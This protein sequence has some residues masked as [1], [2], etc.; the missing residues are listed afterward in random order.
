MIFEA[1]KSHKISKNRNSYFCI[2]FPFDLL[3]TC[4]MTHILLTIQISFH[5]DKGKIF[6]IILPKFGK[7]EKS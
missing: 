5:F 6:M 2:E 3:R 1:V 7:T 4:K